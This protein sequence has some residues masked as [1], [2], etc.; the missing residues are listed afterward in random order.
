MWKLR[1]TIFYYD[2]R[3]R[4]REREKERWREERG[5]PI[6]RAKRRIMKTQM[7]YF[8]MQKNKIK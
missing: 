4:E 3:E 7:T 5:V 8:T 2:K 1:H 6:L